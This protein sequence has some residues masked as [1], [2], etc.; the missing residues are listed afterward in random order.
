M[1][2]RRRL[3]AL[4]LTL[5]ALAGLTAC[6]YKHGY[7]GTDMPDPCHIQEEEVPAVA[8]PKG[9]APVPGPGQS[10]VVFSLSLVTMAFDSSGQACLT[11]EPTDLVW[12]IHMYGTVDGVSTWH[13]QDSGK[14]LPADVRKHAPFAADF[15]LL[16]PA[17]QTP[18]VS[19]DFSAKHF[20]TDTLP[21]HGVI[22]ACRI[23]M[24]GA[25]I[26]VKDTYPKMVGG[27]FL[28]CQATVTVY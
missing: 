22:A 7:F 25:T 4:L 16:H 17:D 15:Y 2:S 10:M 18:V 24:N 27:D 6:G 9:A 26:A 3:A 21:V 5:V 20:P 13:E 12:D 28:H 11:E 8:K 23:R 1:S 14:L 19:F